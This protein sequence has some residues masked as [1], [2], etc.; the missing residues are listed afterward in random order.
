[1]MK[2]LNRAGLALMICAVA[3]FVVTKPSWYWGLGSTALIIGIVVLLID[4][5]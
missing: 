5:D 1:M 2:A 3:L 4:W